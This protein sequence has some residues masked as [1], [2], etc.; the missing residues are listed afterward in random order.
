MPKKLPRGITAEQA[1]EI[2]D[3]ELAEAIA[4][5]IKAKA[6]TRS[7]FERRGK[8]EWGYASSLGHAIEQVEDLVAFLDG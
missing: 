4:D 6:K 1:F 5:L 3:K 2:R 7:H 8:T